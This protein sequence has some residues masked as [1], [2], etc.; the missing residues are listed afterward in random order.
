MTRGRK[1]DAPALAA[2]KGNPGRRRRDTPAARAAEL[3]AAAAE[4]A[5]PLAPPRYLR[6]AK[7]RPALAIWRQLVGEL[8]RFNLLDTL[9]RGTFA[10]YCVHMADWIAA[11]K[12]IAKYGHSYT[13]KNVNND[14]L[15]RLNPAVKVRELAERHILEI[16]SRFGLDP[17]SRYRLLRDQS[18]APL[19]GL[20]GSASEGLSAA[21]APAAEEE[22][23]GLMRRAS[24]APRTH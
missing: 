6:D 18:A 13:A 11:T 22:P 4:S 15:M 2:A 10:M 3:A 23:V 14:D 8:R 19:G 5:D 1:P 21:P 20:F 24:E 7:L 9:D 12:D 16:G 17:A